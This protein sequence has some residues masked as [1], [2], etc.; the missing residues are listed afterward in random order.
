M[1]SFKADENLYNATKL[2]ALRA[3][4]IIGNKSLA[5]KLFQQAA[6]YKMECDK[7]HLKAKGG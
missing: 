7:K 2:M 3:A 4:I 5:K 1:L 6:Q